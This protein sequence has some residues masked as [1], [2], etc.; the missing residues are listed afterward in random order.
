MGV[1][2]GAV[3]VAS[4]KTYVDLSTRVGSLAGKGQLS[5]AGASKSQEIV[6]LGQQLG[7]FPEGRAINGFLSHSFDRFCFYGRSF[8]APCI[9]NKGQHGCQ[10]EVERK[11]VVKHGEARVF[12]R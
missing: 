9:S 10:F 1:S 6:S 8:V 2:I 7:R 4:S 5:A 12:T 3:A 11:Q